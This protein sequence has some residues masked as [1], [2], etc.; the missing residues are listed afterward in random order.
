[1]VCTAWPVRPLQRAQ[2]WQGPG[3]L[4]WYIVP[5]TEVCMIRV[6][7]AKKLLHLSASGGRK[8]LTC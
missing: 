5:K 3:H 6:A 8:Q 1:M 4:A 7:K 2:V